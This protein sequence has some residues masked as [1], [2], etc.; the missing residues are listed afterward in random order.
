MKTKKIID[1]IDKEIESAY[2]RIASGKQISI[3][4]IPKVFSDSR[5]AIANGA[6]VDQAVRAAVLMYCIE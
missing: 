1:L 6:E 4:D 2:Y 3:M 5:R